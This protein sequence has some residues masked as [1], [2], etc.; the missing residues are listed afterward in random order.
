MSTLKEIVPIRETRREMELWAI[1]NLQFSYLG[2]TTGWVR[3]SMGF[4]NLFNEPPPFSAAAFNDS[5]DS[6][7][8]DITGRFGYLRLERAL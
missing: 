5:Y 8:Y 7:T 4:N 1:H 2:P 6:R 3:I